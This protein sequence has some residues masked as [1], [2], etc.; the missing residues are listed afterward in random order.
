MG[1]SAPVRPVL[2]SPPEEAGSWL[3]TT[4]RPAGRMTAGS[5]ARF[6]AALDAVS[7]CS[8]VVLVDLSAVGPLPRRARRALA[9][10]DARLTAAGGAL[11]V[12]GR[13]EPGSPDPDGPV[14]LPPL[15]AGG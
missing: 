13:D 14:L 4:L 5:A 9:D 7:R 11:V 2:Q 15:P 1:S 3:T 12:L 6:A 8:G 10:A